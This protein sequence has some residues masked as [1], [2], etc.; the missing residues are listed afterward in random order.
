MIV[1]PSTAADRVQATLQASGV[2]L[3]LFFSMYT[4]NRHVERPSIPLVERNT[5]VGR[6]YTTPHKTQMIDTTINLYWL[7]GWNAQISPALP[8]NVEVGCEE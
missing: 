4:N 1:S 6:N 2:Q 5:Q 8:S 3:V 7:T